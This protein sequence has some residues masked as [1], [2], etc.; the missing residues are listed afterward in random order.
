MKTLKENE[1][2]SG[3]CGRRERVK[4][5]R[6]VDQ[7][8]TGWDRGRKVGSVSSDSIGILPFGLE[9]GKDTFERFRVQIESRFRFPG[10]VLIEGRETRGEEGEKGRY[11]RGRCVR[12]NIEDFM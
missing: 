12:M 7:R 11:E 8:K 10:D 3:F 9:P 4:S 5:Y 1:G 2:G 6:R